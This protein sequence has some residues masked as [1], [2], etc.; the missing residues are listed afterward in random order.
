[1]VEVSSLNMHHMLG[2]GRGTKVPNKLNTEKP[3]YLLPGA[4]T[5]FGIFLIHISFHLG[6]TNND[7]FKYYSS[8]AFY[9]FH[10]FKK[11]LWVLVQGHIT[12]K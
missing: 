1:M 11:I 6:N 4:G 8:K 3:V 2:R 9:I 5:L 7:F 12:N 10:N